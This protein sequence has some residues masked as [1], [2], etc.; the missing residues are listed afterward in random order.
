MFHDFHGAWFTLQ[1]LRLNE[2]LSEVELLVIDNDPTYNGS[3]MLKSHM[4]GQMHFHNLGARYIAYPDV[5][6]PANAKN[7][8]F[9]QARGEFVLCLDSHVLLKHGTIAKLIDWYDRHPNCNDLISGPLIYD[10]LINTS[11][12]FDDVWRGEMWGIWGSA[13]ITPDG[14]TFS[15]LNEDNKAV[16]VELRFGHH[17]LEDLTI[18]NDYVGHEAYLEELDCRKLGQDGDEF[19]IPGNGC[20]LISCRKDAWLGFNPSW[21]GFGGEEM[22]I[23]EKFRQAG[24]KAICLGFLKWLHRFGRPEGVKFPLRRWDKI[25]NYVLGHVELGMDLKPVYDH[26]VGQ[27]LMPVHEWKSV[28]EDPERLEPIMVLETL[29][30][31]FL[32]VANIKR[33]LNEHMPDLRKMAEECESVTE[34]GTRRESTIAFLC[35]KPKKLVSYSP[36]NNDADLRRVVEY[37]KDEVDITLEMKWSDEVPDIEQTDLLFIDQRHTYADV[38]RELLT[39]GPKVNRFIV[40]HDTELFGDKGEDGGPGLK[41]AVRG[42]LEMYPEWAW[43]F[44]HTRQFGLAVLA[45]QPADK[46]ATPFNPWVIGGPGT[47]LT[48][49]MESLGVNASPGCDCKKKARS[50]DMWGVVGCKANRDVIVGWIKENKARWGWGDKLDYAATKQTEI[51]EKKSVFDKVAVIWKTVTTGLIFKINAF[52]QEGSLVD[53]CIRRAEAKEKE[54]T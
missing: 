41:D 34:F 48:L 37:V 16:C 46:P 31:I 7:Q 9:E 25:R 36:E 11:T 8:V 23:H 51:P 43:N 15:V 1:S 54:R 10:D 5:K 47:E 52:D 4:D 33:D 32:R 49:I 35:G 19:E 14:R 28:I 27:N 13:W 38:T 3:S 6:G 45:K 22:Y 42:F 29:D 2:D 20:G 50:M 17:I 39:Y 26:F 12:H 24:H 18:G 44:Y 30:E 21:R 40:L 53:E